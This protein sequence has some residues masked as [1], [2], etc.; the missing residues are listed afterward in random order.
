MCQ[1]LP[2]DGFEWVD[3]TGW[4]HNTIQDKELEEGKGLILEVDLHFPKEL[5]DKFSDY[6]LAPTHTKITEDIISPFSKAAKVKGTCS[7]GV[8]LAPTL[9]DRKNYVVHIRN[10]KFYLEEG[11]VITSVHRAVTFNESCWLAS[12]IN[13][14]TEQRKKAR[15]DLEKAFWKLLN[16]ALFG[17]IIESVRKRNNII[18]VNNEA[19]AIR[20]ASKPEYK[21]FKILSDTLVA[22]ETR[23][24]Q[25]VFDKP[26]Y[27]GFTVLDLSKLLMM[28]FH[29]RV[30]TKHFNSL[31]CFTDTDSFL[32]KLHT[33]DL[34]GTQIPLLRKHMDLSNYPSDHPLFSTDNKAIIGLFKDETEGKPIESFIGLRSK[35]YSVMVQKGKRKMAAAGVPRCIAARDLTHHRFLEALNS[36][37][38]YE[39]NIK[40]TGI[41]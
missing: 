16:N 37:G 4:D 12:Y 23:K 25:I 20:I 30:M 22:V 38:P 35:M 39:F 8:K 3:T 9:F 13:S 27:I 41:R 21:R 40:Q 26:I 6:P 32:Y 17:K 10:L 1:S 15:D 36:T 11:A 7:D 14:N 5:H 31:L 34:Y 2:V 18:L 33:K 29:Y 19:S 24:T 28:D